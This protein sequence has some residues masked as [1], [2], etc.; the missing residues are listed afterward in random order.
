VSDEIVSALD[1]FPAPYGRQVSL[2][3]VKHDSG[4]RMLRLR[5]REGSRFT[6]MD[7]DEATATRWASV[8][9]SWASDAG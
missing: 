8:M 3:D 4:L 2:D 7:I 1:S 6:V 5:I 9:S